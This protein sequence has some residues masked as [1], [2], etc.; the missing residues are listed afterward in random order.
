MRANYVYE[1]ADF[2]ALRQAAAKDKSYKQSN[3][4]SSYIIYIG[5]LIFC[6]LI[7]IILITF[8]SIKASLGLY[9]LDPFSMYLGTALYYALIML[10]Y[11]LTKKMRL[12]DMFQMMTGANK[13]ITNTLTENG[14]QAIAS[15]VQSACGWQCILRMETTSEYMFLFIGPAEAFIFP[16]RGF[17][18]QE[19]FESAIAFAKQRVV[20]EGNR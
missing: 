7:P 10:G 6:L 19:D 4:K 5:S 18:S 8:P 9:M 12:Q 11:R 2:L 16:K 17:K 15:H 1:F 20:P 14:I 3:K 13:E